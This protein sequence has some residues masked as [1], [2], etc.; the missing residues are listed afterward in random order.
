VI[1]KS[2][3]T[4]QLQSELGRGGVGVVYLAY[5][6]SLQRQVALKVLPLHLCGHPDVVARFLKEARA[7]ARLSHPG[8]VE[9]YTIGCEEGVHFFAMELLT[10]SSLEAILEKEGALSPDK[11]L[12]IALRV[13]EALDHAHRK[14]FIH[15]DIKPSNIMIDRERDLVK[16]TDFGIAKALE[17]GTQATASEVRLGTPRYMSPEQVRG[18]TLDPRSDVF[19]L[20]V[21]LFQ[22]L[23][24]RGPFGG[25]SFLVVMRNI[26]EREPEFLP[27]DEAAVPAGVREVVGKAMVKNPEERFR[28]AGELA[29]ELRRLL[30]EEAP[31]A[32]RGPRWW[33]LA[34]LL[35]AAAAAAVGLLRFRGSE[36]EAVPLPEPV[37]AP[38]PAPSAPPPTPVA[39]EEEFAALLEFLRS[40][41]DGLEEGASRCR[42][43]LAAYPDSPRAEAVRAEAARLDAARAERELRFRELM[44]EGNG[45]ARAGRWKEAGGAYA[46]AGEFDA[47][48]EAEAAGREAR[49]QGLLAS[50][51]SAPDPAAAVALCRQA[52]EIFPDR[53]E[54]G[55]ELEKQQERLDRAAAARRDL[56]NGRSLLRQ[57]RVREAAAALSSAVELDPE[58]NEAR[59]LLEDARARLPGFI[60]V[61]VTPAEAE[62]YLDGTYRG[63]GTVLERIE[64]APG[65]HA[66]RVVHP[67]YR[68]YSGEVTVAPERESALRIGLSPLP[69]PVPRNE[70]KAPL[71]VNIF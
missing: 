57:G 30:G 69:T 40:H 56:E 38:L 6:R 34:L 66:V 47:G 64:A 15:R 44:D 65:L 48:G 16:V 58:G 61:S 13:A 28:S 3:G 2:L 71:P 10:G 17:S 29:R 21:V 32:R 22:M 51:R 18:E 50:A 23:T 27:Q 31:R 35:A 68:P 8:I 46:R 24:G 9:I 41:P 36:P 39:G 19:S 60:L 54:A 62:V 33:P 5:A 4:Y 12:R 52:L 11:A 55:A 14:G 59:A 20:G 67:G 26:L 63:R 7:A 25:D 49:F 43:F 1:G 70:R 45:F 42:E 37:P 53:P